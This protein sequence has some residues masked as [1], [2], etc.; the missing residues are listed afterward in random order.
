MN[1]QRH[2]QNMLIVTGFGIVLHLSIRQRYGQSHS[3]R[4]GVNRAAIMHVVSSHY[5]PTGI[6][7]KPAT[8]TPDKSTGISTQY[9]RTVNIQALQMN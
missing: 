5:L 2:V 9:R 3:I 4:R 1:I 7:V 6:E 8:L